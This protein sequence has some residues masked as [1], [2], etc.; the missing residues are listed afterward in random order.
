[1]YFV[2]YIYLHRAAKPVSRLARGRKNR[3]SASVGDLGHI[4]GPVWHNFTTRSYL[5]LFL[6]PNR[7]FANN[8]NHEALQIL[9]S[10]E[11]DG[12]KLKK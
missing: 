4:Y 11:Y 10:H 7:S 5:K 6:L 12:M 8:F 3:T 2:N 9:L 1:L